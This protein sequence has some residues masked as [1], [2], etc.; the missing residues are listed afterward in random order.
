MD[1]FYG[2]KVILHTRTEHSDMGYRIRDAGLSLL[3]EKAEKSVEI[4]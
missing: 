2:Y 4:E 1:S 3:G